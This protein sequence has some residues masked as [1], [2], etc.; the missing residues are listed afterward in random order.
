[1]RNLLATIGLSHKQADYQGKGVGEDAE[2]RPK[3]VEIHASTIP[4]IRPEVARNLVNQHYREYGF[5]VRS[6]VGR[7][8]VL[9]LEVYDGPGGWNLDAT[10]DCLV[11]AT[12]VLGY[13]LAGG[14]EMKSR[15]GRTFFTATAKPGREI[16]G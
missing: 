12:A 11:K 1:M 13:R 14:I 4:H 16:H 8:G 7:N 15:F 9:G 6:A 5:R 10:L 2:D 3:D